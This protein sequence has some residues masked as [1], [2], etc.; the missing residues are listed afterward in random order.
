MACVC[1]LS[2]LAVPFDPVLPLVPP[3]ELLRRAVR[4]VV[5]RPRLWRNL[6]RCRIVSGSIRCRAATAAAALLVG[7]S[8]RSDCASEA[9][10]TPAAAR[11]ERPRH[12]S[13]AASGSERR[14]GGQL[15]WR[16]RYRCSRAAA[17]FEATRRICRTHGKTVR[18]TD[19]QMLRRVGHVYSPKR[20]RRGRLPCGEAHGT[21]AQ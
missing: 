1:L 20:A 12:L 6:C 7:A 10:S 15:W 13:H 8:V 14:L 18:Q 5:A 11:R 2:E 16:V 19:R 21:F 4:P 3:N 17:C 9:V